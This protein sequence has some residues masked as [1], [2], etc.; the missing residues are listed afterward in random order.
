M[1]SVRDRDFV[2]QLLNRL[3]FRDEILGA[4]LTHRK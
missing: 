2:E 1:L 3:S 4:F